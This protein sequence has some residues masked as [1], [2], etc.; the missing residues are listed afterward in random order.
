MEVVV[1]KEQ[2]WESNKDLKLV[3]LRFC[4][5]SECCLCYCMMC[6]LCACNDF[7]FLFASLVFVSKRKIRR[8]DFLYY[9]LLDGTCFPKKKGRRDK[10]ILISLMRG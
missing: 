4:S 7:S 9:K 3:S 5:V 8:W 10:E 1:V 6:C 2:K